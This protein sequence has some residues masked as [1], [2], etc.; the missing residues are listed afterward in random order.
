MSKVETLKHKGDEIME[1]A[2]SDI[3]VVHLK[4]IGQ[5]V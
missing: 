2:R 3:Q 4:W 1:Q 5:Y